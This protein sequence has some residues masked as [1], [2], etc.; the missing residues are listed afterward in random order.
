MSNKETNTDPLPSNEGEY[1]EIVN[2]LKKQYDSE[3]EKWKAKFTILEKQNKQMKKFIKKINNVTDE[4]IKSDNKRIFSEIDEGA[5]SNPRPRRR[6]RIVRRDGNDMT[7]TERE[8]F[9]FLLQS[10]ENEQTT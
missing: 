9:R 8:F 3:Q 10:L 2:E 1:L 5:T 7:D 4:I 6:R